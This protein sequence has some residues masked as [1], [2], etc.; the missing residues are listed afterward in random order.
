M[1]RAHLYWGIARGLPYPS[2]GAAGDQVVYLV[3]QRECDPI[4]LTWDR[5]PETEKPA[6]GA[7][8][9][10]RLCQTVLVFPLHFL[11]KRVPQPPRT[12]ASSAPRDHPLRE[13]RLSD[14]RKQPAEPLVAAEWGFCAAEQRSR[15]GN[16]DSLQP[17]KV[18]L[19]DVPGL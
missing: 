8:L 6:V 12:F 10:N 9:R 17:G 19:A 5:K 1:L 13:D 16:G 2:A 3:G 4:S 11:S 7:E 15:F 14:Q 18:R